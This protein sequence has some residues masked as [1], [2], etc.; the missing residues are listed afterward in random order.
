MAFMK[1]AQKRYFV[2]LMGS[3]LLYGAALYFRHVYA[4]AHAAPSVLK[5]VILLSPIP[6]VCLA[7]IAI[8]RFYNR[9]DEMIR[10]QMLENIALGALL[11]SVAAIAISFLHDVG[12][13]AAGIGLAW[14]LLGVCWMLATLYRRF[15]CA[16]SEIGPG[17]TLREVLRVIVPV[18]VLTP[19]YALAAPHFGW[20]HE[21]GF[22]IMVGTGVFLAGQAY[23]LFVKRSCE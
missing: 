10:R 1:Q 15:L 7:A 6:P 12:L 3:M 21:P 23:Y 9:M 4:D 20:P 18:A 19:L 2:E 14:P 11:M 17:K 13:P 22:V 5:T 8:V 16:I